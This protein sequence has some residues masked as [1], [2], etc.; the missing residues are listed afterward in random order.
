[1]V[2]PADVQHSQ[3]MP[4]ARKAKQSAAER[5]PVVLNELINGIRAM[6]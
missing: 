2:L 6:K 4:T 3:P 1:M 5:G